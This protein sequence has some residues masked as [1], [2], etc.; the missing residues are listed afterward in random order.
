MSPF[1]GQL[2]P[3]GVAR[4]RGPSSWI[5]LDMIV[6]GTD[7]AGGPLEPVGWRDAAVAGGVFALA[8]LVRMIYLQQAW[9]IPLFKHPMVDALAYDKWALEIFAGSWWG[10]EVFYQAPVHPYFLAAVYSIAGPDCTS[11]K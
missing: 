9:S 1:G 10:D 8:L 11:S 2:R 6:G 3:H 7:R 5:A 4:I